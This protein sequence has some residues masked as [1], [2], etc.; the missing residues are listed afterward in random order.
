MGPR[1][2]RAPGLGAPNDVG[3]QS[4]ASD[5]RAVGQ[6]II[7]P[8]LPFNTTAFSS[9]T[10]PSAADF[11]NV[12]QMLGNYMAA[13]GANISARLAPAGATPL[14]VEAGV[15]LIAPRDLMLQSSGRVGASA[16]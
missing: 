1:L 5:T 11:Q 12:D 10:A 15:E 9:A 6:I 13:A 7:E 8:V 14:L 16:L 2:L 4:L 3:T